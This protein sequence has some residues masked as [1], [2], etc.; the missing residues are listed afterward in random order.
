MPSSETIRL[1]RVELS[2]RGLHAF[3]PKLPEYAQ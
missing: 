1:R 2:V 3:S